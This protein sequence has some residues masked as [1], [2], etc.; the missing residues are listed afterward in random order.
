MKLLIIDDDP[1][2]SD[3]LKL[4]LAFHQKD[5]DIRAAGD[6]RTG[7]ALFFDWQPDIVVLDLGLGGIDGA[8][9]LER[10]RGCSTTRVIILSARTG[11][12]SIAKLL[13]LGADA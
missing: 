1:A 6:G 2:I 13:E 7:L 4:S 12:G 3:A 10:I 9:V 5:W 8:N 11:E